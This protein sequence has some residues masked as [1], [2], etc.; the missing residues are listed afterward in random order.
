M[1]VPRLLSFR[2]TAPAREPIARE[3]RPACVA[4]SELSGAV[5]MTASCDDLQLATVRL[6]G[7]WLAVTCVGSVRL[8]RAPHPFNSE[9]NARFVAYLGLSTYFAQMGVQPPGFDSFVW[10]REPDSEAWLA[11]VLG[12]DELGN[13]R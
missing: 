11:R 5:V 9:E 10:R 13:D 4:T 7:K 2:E 1:H 12:P 8:P 6:G 3:R